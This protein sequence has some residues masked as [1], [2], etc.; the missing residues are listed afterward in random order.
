METHLLVQ[1]LVSASDTDYHVLRDMIFEGDFSGGTYI[2]LG[3]EARSGRSRRAG[4][5][6]SA[7]EYQSI[8]EITGDVTISGAEG[9]ASFRRR[10]RHRA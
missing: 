8:P 3:F 4:P 1:R 2:G 7:L 5:R 6:R 9:T 10:R